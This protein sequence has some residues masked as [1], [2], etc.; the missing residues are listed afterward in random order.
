VRPKTR[1]LTQVSWLI[2]CAQLITALVAGAT[3]AAE[4]RPPAWQIF[5]IRYA[6]IPA[7]PVRYLVAGA[8]TT[9]TLDIAMMFW[10]LKGPRGRCLLVDAGFYRKKFIDSWKPADFIQPAEAVRRSGVP[11]DAI[12]DIIVSHV[13]WDHMDGLDLFPKATIWIQRQEYEY[14]VGAGGTPAHAGIDSLDA[15]MLAGLMKAGR[16]KLVEGDGREILP[17]ITAYT[18]GKHTFASQYVGVAM[19]KGTAVVASDNLYLYENLEHHAAIAQTLDAASNLAA[20]DRMRT[21]AS[22]PRLIVPGHDP[23]VF[24]R[25]HGPRPGVARIE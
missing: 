2:L 5:A 7:F 6:T 9:R 24:V 15:P 21:I 23:A 11:P 4:P 22:D 8:D 10:M 18:G 25:F 12:T 13:H 19:A 14:Y 20:Q 3:R 17:G 16:V 1:L